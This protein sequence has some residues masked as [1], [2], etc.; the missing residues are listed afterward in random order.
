L[1]VYQG[2]PTTDVLST[3]GRL[4][5]KEAELP[6]YVLVD[7]TGVVVVFS[8]N[9]PANERF[10]LCHVDTITSN[11]RADPSQPKLVNLTDVIPSLNTE[12]HLTESTLPLKPLNSFKQEISEMSTSTTNGLF[13]DVPDTKIQYEN[14][15]L[16]WDNSFYEQKDYLYFDSTRI[17]VK[18]YSRYGDSQQRNAKNE[19]YMPCITTKL[20]ITQGQHHWCIVFKGDGLSYAGVMSEEE[21]DKL[22]DGTDFDPNKFGILSQAPPIFNSSTVDFYVD[23]NKKTL[24]IKSKQQETV[25]NNLPEKVYPAISMTR[26]A[27]RLAI[28]T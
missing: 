11:F 20:P 8:W 15:A 14:I 27:S 10:Y 21:K 18:D 1:N 23:M 12:Q 2:S 25:L 28:L 24:I 26:K 9:A 3:V 22:R 19:G 6:K 17:A 7:S 5:I 4:F 16:E 13:L